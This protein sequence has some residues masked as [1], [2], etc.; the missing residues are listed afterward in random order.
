[1]MHSST[2]GLHMLQPHN[3]MQGRRPSRGTSGP[4][5]VHSA[6]AAPRRVRPPCRG[7]RG[8]R[9]RA[10]ARARR[11]AAAQ[12]AAAR[13]AAESSLGMAGRRPPRQQHIRPPTPP[14]RSLPLSLPSLSALSLRRCTCTGCGRRARAH[15]VASW[16][17]VEQVVEPLRGD[18]RGARTLPRLTSVGRQLRRRRRMARA[19]CGATRGG[20]MRRDAAAACP[21]DISSERARA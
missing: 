4:R 7:P 9:R 12:R 8:A 16:R 2:D 18:V 11:A 6:G 20:W 13:R 10:S 21:L 3:I 19:R 17:E 5:T 14:P 1:M 15:L